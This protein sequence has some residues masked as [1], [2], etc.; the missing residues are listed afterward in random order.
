MSLNDGSKEVKNGESLIY[1]VARTSSCRLRVCFA[2]VMC[3]N[4]LGPATRSIARLC[5]GN[6][7]GWLCTSFNELFVTAEV[8]DILNTDSNK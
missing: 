2:W 3:R 4:L 1:F 7:A 6:L 5:C 8:D